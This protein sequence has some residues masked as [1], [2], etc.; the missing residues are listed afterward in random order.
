MSDFESVS[1][2]RGLLDV[3]QCGKVSEQAL[4]GHEEEVC[5]A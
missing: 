5:I 4:Y 2:N 3:I 1:G